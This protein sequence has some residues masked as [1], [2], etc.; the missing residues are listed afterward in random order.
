MWYFIVVFMEKNSFDSIPSSM[1]V[2]AATIGGLGVFDGTKRHSDI[3]MNQ[4]EYRRTHDMSQQASILQDDDFV[5]QHA[6]EHL[7]STLGLLVA[8][9]S[10]IVLA[11]RKLRSMFPD[12][13][14]FA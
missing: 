5:L 1:L 7:E 6:S 14:T 10:I 11:R 3:K 2:L 4:A 13:K 8:I 9:P 12:S